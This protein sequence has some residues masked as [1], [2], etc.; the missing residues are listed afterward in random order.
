VIS[1]APTPARR[2]AKGI[3]AM[4]A[5]VVAAA[6]RARWMHAVE[7]AVADRGYAAPTIADITSALQ[8]ALFGAGDRA[9]TW[10]PTYGSLVRATS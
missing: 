9:Q 7:L 3:H 10:L 4:P 6:Q 1:P 5:Q 2:P 8:F